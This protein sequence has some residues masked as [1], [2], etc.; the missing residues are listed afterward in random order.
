MRVTIYSKVGTVKQDCL[1]VRR[2]LLNAGFEIVRVERLKP[3]SGWPLNE[4][5]IRYMVRKY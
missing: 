2:V 4:R 3:R 1:Q 5:R